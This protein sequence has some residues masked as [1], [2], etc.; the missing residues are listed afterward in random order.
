MSS[1]PAEFHN[2]TAHAK[3]NVYFEGK[4]ISHTLLLPDK[5]KKTL[6]LIYPGKYHFGTL[7]AEHMEIVAGACQ[8]VLDGKTGTVS[9]TAGQSF[10]VPANSGFEIE[11]AHGI[12]EYIC[13]FLS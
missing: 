5:T 6:G 7:A 12:C 8:V 2:V 9:F 3:A 13:T 10:G 11:V 4:V 1:V